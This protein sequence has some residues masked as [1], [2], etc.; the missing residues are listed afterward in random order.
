MKYWK[1]WNIGALRRSL[2]RKFIRDYCMAM[3][4]SFM[5]YCLQWSKNLMQIVS[6]CI[7]LLTLPIGDVRNRGGQEIVITGEFGMVRNLLSLWIPICRVLW[8][9]LVS[10]R[11]RKWRRL[12]LLLPPKIIRL[13]RKW[14]MPIRRVVLEIH[15]FV[16]IWNAIISFLKVLK[17]LSMSD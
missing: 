10:S 14:W 5:N 16:L 9:N 12:Q 11:S 1:H 8:V 13:N 2:L 6:M 15:W 17:I 4:N 3:I 7:V